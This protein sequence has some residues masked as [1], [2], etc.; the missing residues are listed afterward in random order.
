WVDGSANVFRTIEV[1]GAP[2]IVD[3]TT[4]RAGVQDIVKHCK[5]AHINTV[6]VDVKPLSGQVLYNSTIAPHMRVWKGHPLPDFD[7]LAAFVEEGHKAG[8][9]IDASINV[10]SEGHKYFSV[11]PAYQHTDWQSQVYTVDRGLFAPDGARLSARVA[12]EPDD[13]AK[14]PILT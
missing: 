1:N 3:Y 14:P 2:T 9:Q 8:L 10:L 4:T 12:G 5:A 7:V 11:G 6:V 13:Q